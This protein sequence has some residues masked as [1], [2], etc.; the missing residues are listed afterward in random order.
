[1][2]QLRRTRRKQQQINI[3]DNS[4]RLLEV[5]YLQVLNSVVPTPRKYSHSLVEYL[6]K[7]DVLRFAGACSLIP[8]IFLSMWIAVVVSFSLTIGM[9]AIL[10]VQVGLVGLGFFVYLTCQGLILGTFISALVI[11]KGGQRL[12]GNR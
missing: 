5:L 8:L 1:M 10:S 6:K 2:N 3:S 12:I 11:Y 9:I 4:D 7:N